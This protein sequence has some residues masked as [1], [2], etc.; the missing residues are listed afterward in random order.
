[1]KINKS[2]PQNEEFFGYY[3]KLIPTLFKVGFL[4]Q[5]FSA[6]IETFILYSI[7]RPK[8]QGVTEYPERAAL[9]GALLLVAL[10][11]VGLRSSAAFSVRA[12]LYRKFKGLDLFMTLFIFILCGALLLCSVVLHIEGSKEAVEVNAGAPA[13]EQTAHIE[14]SGQSEAAGLLRSFSQDSGAVA[15][16]YAARMKSTRAEYQAKERAY[17]SK[18][19]ATGAG[20]A[21]IRAKGEAKIAALEAER[22][23]KF[24]RLLER[25]DSRLER[26]KTR[27]FSAVDEIGGRNK[28]RL[29]RAEE[30]VDKYSSYLST[31]SVL[32]VVFFL[33]TIALNEI[34]KKGAGIEEVAIA[35]QY[36][37]EQPVF[38]KLAT[39]VNDKFQ[40]HARRAIDRIEES[41]PGPR[42]PLAPHP[43]YDYSGLMPERVA[44]QTR[45]RQH[46]AL[47]PTNSANSQGGEERKQEKHYEYFDTKMPQIGER[48]QPTSLN[49][50]HNGSGAQTGAKP[51]EDENGGL[52]VA[53]KQT[54]NGGGGANRGGNGSGNTANSAPA[55]GLAAAILGNDNSQERP[56]AFSENSAAGDGGNAAQ[57]ANANSREYF[58]FVD[59]DKAA[60]T[61][62][63][64]GKHY[65]LRDVNSFVNT[66]TKRAEAA[67]KQR[68]EEA[69]RSREEA[70]A[71][72]QSRRAELLKK[73]QAAG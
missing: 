26:V 10:L 52:F 48:K 23:E 37:F 38:A 65:G 49:G 39:A 21:A 61:I 34:H 15:A 32:T 17:N 67:R 29:E 35:S 7:L 69:L 33:L 14:T 56:P 60:Y 4:S 41:T 54:P 70:V 50:K 43:L 59:K 47:P 22:G 66:Y 46:T 2:L 5:L 57:T 18:R 68:N 30:R 25:K 44:M 16:T 51:G 20:A 64:N 8:F 31:F 53:T 72:W 24:E 9:L 58:Y 36:H 63:H 71:Y 6:A 12:I 62:E 55:G 13:L 28:K 11:E 3:A 19:G 1:M 40:Y 42:A 27:Q 73:M 45:E